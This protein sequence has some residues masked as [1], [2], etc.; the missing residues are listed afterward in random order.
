MVVTSDAGT[1]IGYTGMRLRGSD[2]TRINVTIN[3]VPLNDAESHNVFWVDLP[4]LMGSVRELQI[5]RG[6]GTSTNGA[7]SF[8]GTLSIQTN[9][10][11]V[12]PYLE[13][14]GTL[15]S[16][17]T[18][19]LSVKAGTGLINDRYTIDARYSLIKSD[20]FID[21]ATADLQS[22]NFSAAR[23]TGR[24]SIRLNILHGSEVTYQAWYGVP[25][26][27]FENKPEALLTHYYNNVG[28]IY[29]N[30]ADSV[31]LFASDERYN[32]YTYPQQVDNYRQTHFQLLHSLSV[33]PSLKLK[34]TLFYT[35]GKGFFEEFKYRD[36]L[37]NYGLSP[38]MDSLGQ[39][40][41][42]V[43][44]VRR[45]WLDNHFV[46][47]LAD[48]E[49]QSS[50]KWLWQ[51]GVAA[52]RYLGSHFGNVIQTA[53]PVSGW[54]KET[55][56]YDNDGHKTDMASYFR[57]IWSPSQYWQI[58]ADVQ[59]RVVD[60]TVRGIDND[61]RSIDVGKEIVFINPKTGVSYQ[62]N[63]ASQFYLSYAIGQKEPSRSDFI[64]NAFGIIPTPEF[65]QN[66]EGGARYQSDKLALESGLYYMKYKNQLVLTGEL[67]DV[68]APVRTNVP[69]SYRLGWENTLKYQ[70]SS[71]WAVMLTSTLSRNKIASFREKI[72]DYTNG[73]EVREVS[74]QNT[75]ISFSPNLSAA[76]QILC[77]PARQFEAEWSFRYV[78][79][80]YL[81]NTSNEQRQLPAYHYQNLRL[82]WK[83]P[84][85]WTTKATV[86][87]F[88]NNLLNAR[89]ASNG[90][91]Y[92][93]IYG[94]PITENYVYP[95]AGR[96]IMCTFS[97]GW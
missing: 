86:S 97:V 88:V 94:S 55:R 8:G 20:G 58:H 80:Q 29:K 22:L 39:E 7:G 15:G 60:Y 36:A 5:Q 52:N 3:G 34:T 95:Q 42:D 64:D 85:H 61:L 48:A 45:R 25:Q 9:D 1:G 59:G 66:W 32:Y 40:V 35:R 27:K 53:L 21:R 79:A 62:A 11:R 70:V 43:D 67:N 71:K 69:N 81:D 26:A 96:H 16:F 18:R 87:L 6:V 41:S 74:H 10:V 19:K 30:A 76:S 83:S 13:L 78:S 82:T 50:P 51:A 46:G 37:Q 44:I 72:A 47:V 92:T 12:N 89:Y 73:F 24:S 90:Y 33:S 17:D 2:Q 77:R 84:E 91:S 4:D 57:T 31:N 28:S 54:S 68:G 38:A 14:N 49:W 63:A 93:Y 23:V 56:Y 75:E 65:L